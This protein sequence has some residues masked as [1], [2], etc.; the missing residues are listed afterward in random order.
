MKITNFILAVMFMAFAFV[1]INDPDPLLWIAIYGAMA[2]MCIMAAFRYYIKPLLWILLAGFLVYMVILWP[3]LQE[4]LRQ[5]DKGVLFDEGM[6]MQFPYI[7]ESRE[8]LGLLIC[9][10]VLI[11]QIVRSRK[12]PSNT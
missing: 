4:W 6:K 5:E 7:E 9:V 2:V 8:F 3:G 1:Q 10:I 11:A 12:Q